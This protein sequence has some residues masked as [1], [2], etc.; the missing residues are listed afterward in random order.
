MILPSPLR[1]SVIRLPSS[2]SLPSQDDGADLAFEGTRGGIVVALGGGCRAGA[3]PK[4]T[5]GAGARPKLLAVRAG[6]RAGGGAGIL[7]AS[8]SASCMERMRLMADAAHS[9][10]SPRIFDASPPSDLPPAW[11]CFCIEGCCR[12]CKRIASISVD[13]SARWTRAA[14]SSSICL[15]ACINW[16]S[17][18]IAV[19]GDSLAAAEGSGAESASSSFFFVSDSSRRSI[20]FSS[21]RAATTLEP[22]DVPQQDA[23]AAVAA[24]PRAAARARVD[25]SP[26]AAAAANA[27]GRL[28]GGIKLDVSDRTICHIS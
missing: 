7:S 20:R 5:G 4:L 6:A 22:A 27:V 8:S 26:R 21:S 14:L 9:G 28:A 3:R 24:T 19:D 16:A 11:A 13:N 17:T 23:G 15:R 10:V 18:H 25:T 1:R 2:K 12:S